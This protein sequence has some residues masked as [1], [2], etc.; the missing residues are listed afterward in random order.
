MPFAIATTSVRSHGGCAAG[1]ADNFFQRPSFQPDSPLPTSGIDRWILPPEAVA[2]D[3]LT[4]CRR[5]LQPP[6]VNAAKLGE[7]EAASRRTTD[8]HVLE[9]ARTING[10]RGS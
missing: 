8:A 3:L 2:I 5:G 4:L 6:Q 7:K 1:F 10:L 9:D